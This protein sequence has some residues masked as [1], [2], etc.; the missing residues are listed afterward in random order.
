MP[1]YYTKKL[2]EILCKKSSKKSEASLQL[3]FALNSKNYYFKVFIK[4]FCRRNSKN[5]KC[6]FIVKS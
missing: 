5:K 1:L 2:F 3:A 4:F 6:F